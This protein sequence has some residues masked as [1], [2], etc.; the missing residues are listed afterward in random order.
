MKS[1]DTLKNEDD[2]LETFNVLKEESEEAA[3]P[4]WRQMRKNSMVYMGDH[5]VR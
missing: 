2:I 1:F 4:R 3:R 5:Y